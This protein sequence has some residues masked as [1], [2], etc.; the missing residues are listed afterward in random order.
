MSF[1]IIS[2]LSTLTQGVLNVIAVIFLVVFAM[3]GGLFPL[4][5]WLPRS[6]YGPPA[7]IAA[8]FGALLTKVGIYAIMHV[9]YRAWW[10]LYAS[11]ILLTLC[12]D[13]NI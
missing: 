13:W 3:K 5:F 11:W 2:T 6:Y 8:L 12:D 4:Y 7:A 9:D 10:I 1:S